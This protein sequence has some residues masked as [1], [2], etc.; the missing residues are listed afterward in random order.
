MRTLVF[1]DPA[2][3]RIREGPVVC[4]TAFFCASFSSLNSSSLMVYN[5]T[6]KYV[7]ANLKAQKTVDETVG[8]LQQFMT[9]DLEKFS[10]LV[11]VVVAPS[12]VALEK[13][14]EIVKNSSIKLS[15]QDISSLPPGAHTGEVSA[16]ALKPF[17]KYTLIGHS[18]RR[19]LLNESDELLNNKVVQANDAGIT[20]IYFMNGETVDVPANVQYI[21]YEPAGAIGVGNEISV[22]QVVEQ[23]NRADPEKKY[24]YF[25]G[26][27]V[28]PENAAGYLNRDEIDG[29]IVGTEALDPLRFYKI[30][31]TVT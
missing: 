8:W 3:A 5:L 27:S 11:E 23:G 16:Q 17:V 19:R 21:V 9:Q 22:D 12:F 2:P 1:P 24:V 13:A 15:S 6:M 28:T 30:I 18:E 25:Y 10:G 14:F 4:I 7:V 26:G 31:S 29:V 20:P